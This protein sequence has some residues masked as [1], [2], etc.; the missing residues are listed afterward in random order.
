M[1]KGKDLTYAERIKIE[2]ML[3]DGLNKKQIAHRL[4]RHY[5]TIHYE[6]KKGMTRL[7]DGSTWKEYDF[8]SADIGQATHEQAQQNKGCPLKIG[9]DIAY[10]DYLETMV[11]HHKYSP[12]AALESAKGKFDTTIC[13]STFYSYVDKGVFF[14]LENRDLPHRKDARIRAYKPRRTSLK[15]LH[16]KSI[17]ER[18]KVVNER[19]SKGH[20]ELDTVVGG[21]GKSKECLMVLT[22]RVS[23]REL[24]MK[25]ASKTMSEVVRAFNRLEQ[26]L[27]TEHFKE[28]FRTITADNGTEFLDSDG[29]EKSCIT[30]GN[31]TNVYF[32]HPYCPSERGSNEN[33]NKLIRRWCPKGCD[34]AE[35]TE[36]DIQ[37]IEDWLNSYP[38][39]LFNGRTANEVYLTAEK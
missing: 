1:G 19:I 10:A 7:R 5:N 3:K 30:A 8:Y 20:W 11:I 39:K 32:C 18:P 28:T 34:F 4:G 14:S 37:H 21:R 35:Y 26:R 23:R 15:N 22:E 38:R 6:I 25:L 16:A 12:Y 24:I 33:A 31:R 2:T 17:E 9:K 13:V 27:G 36:V 29:I